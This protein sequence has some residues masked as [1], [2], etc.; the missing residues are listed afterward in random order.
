MDFSPAAG[1]CFPPPEV[2]SRSSGGN[3]VS[4]LFPGKHQGI[5]SAVMRRCCRDV[6]FFLKT[7]SEFFE[8]PLEI[9]EKAFEISETIR[10]FSETVCGFSE[11]PAVFSGDAG[12]FSVN[13]CFF[14]R[15]SRPFGCGIRRVF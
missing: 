9:S 15:I 3:S 13:P 1:F 5:F 8:T 6:S 2:P 11:N 14:R 12:D 4:L 7:P 10:G